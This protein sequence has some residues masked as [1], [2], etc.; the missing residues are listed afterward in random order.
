MLL[1][2]ESSV[3]VQIL[4]LTIVMCVAS[5]FLAVGKVKKVDPADVF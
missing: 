1:T 4:V 2:P 5:G 3:R